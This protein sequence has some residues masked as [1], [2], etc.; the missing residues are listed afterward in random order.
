[1]SA[2]KVD[3]QA[4][5]AR[6]L[7][8]KN[9]VPWGGIWEEFVEEYHKILKKLQPLK[10]DIEDFIIEESHFKRSITSVSARGTTYSDKRHIDHSFFM[11]KLD[12]LINLIE[13][14]SQPWATLWLKSN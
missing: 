13:I 14:K 10:I 4:I 9:N 3:L 12:W 1:M 6:L 11:M 2:D 8:M 7:A 5:Y